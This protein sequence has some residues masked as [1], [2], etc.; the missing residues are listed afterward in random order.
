MR[1]SEIGYIIRSAKNTVKSNWIS[2]L[3]GQDLNLRPLGYEPKLEIALIC[4]PLPLVTRSC[5]IYC[6]I[7]P[8]SA[9]SLVTVLVTLPS[10]PT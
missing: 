1:V 5:C 6:P 8:W 4:P 3:R 9:L 10:V 2:W 7:L